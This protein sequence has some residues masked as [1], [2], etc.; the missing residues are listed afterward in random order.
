MFR[1]KA[2]ACSAS[3]LVSLSRGSSRVD[4][5]D[6]T[7]A[8]ALFVLR[9]EMPPLYPV[10]ASQPHLS[11]LP[12]V[13]RIGEGGERGQ[14]AQ[15]RLSRP[16]ADPLMGISRAVGREWARMGGLLSVPCT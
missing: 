13:T 2:V 15:D 14:V 16:T 9:M 6:L 11:G 4:S 5:G 7:G 10:H 12:A 8:T 1:G 3:L